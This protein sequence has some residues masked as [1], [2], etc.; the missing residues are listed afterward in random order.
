MVGTTRGISATPRIGN[1]KTGRSIHYTNQT[2]LMIKILKSPSLEMKPLAENT[3]RLIVFLRFSLILISLSLAQITSAWAE[4]D[5]DAPELGLLK[6]LKTNPEA[7]E[8]KD[9]K[10]CALAFRAIFAVG[11]D[12]QMV[13]VS[14]FRREGKPGESYFVLETVVRPISEHNSERLIKNSRELKDNEVEEL[15]KLLDS[16][17]MF[18]LPTVRSQKDDKDAIFG[19]AEKWDAKKGESKTIARDLSE[20]RVMDEFLRVIYLL[21]RTV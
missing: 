15:L 18:D 8:L 6:R 7:D 3:H 11:R 21:A 14:C 1:L 5:K 19:F 4:V 17:E 10:D 9:R 20:S 13:T 2:S 16:Q 12:D